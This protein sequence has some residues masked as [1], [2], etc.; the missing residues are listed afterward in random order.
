VRHFGHLP[1]TKFSDLFV[2]LMCSNPI[3]ENQKPI[4]LTTFRWP[5]GGGVMGGGVEDKKKQ[6]S[7]L[8]M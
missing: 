4:Y 3:F 8:L 6:Q 5:G 7:N 2:I 1:R